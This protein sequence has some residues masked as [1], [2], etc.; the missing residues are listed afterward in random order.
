MDTNPGPLNIVAPTGEENQKPP[1]QQ[2]N[3]PSQPQKQT[4]RPYLDFLLVAISIYGFAVSLVVFKTLGILVYVGLLLVLVRL[5][6]KNNRSEL[7]I[8]I[9]VGS[10]L[11]FLLY[12]IQDALHLSTNSSMWLVKFFVT[13]SQWQ[14]VGFAPAVFSLISLGLYSLTHVLH[15][16]FGRLVSDSL[17][18]GI[19]IFVLIFSPFINSNLLDF[20]SAQKQQEAN[21]ETTQA[22]PKDGLQLYVPVDASPYKLEGILAEHGAESSPN[23]VFSAYS[24][25]YSN[26]QTKD[27]ISVYEGIKDSLFNPPQNCG[28]PSSRLLN[29]NSLVPC[30]LLTTTPKG[31]TVY[32]GTSEKSTSRSTN[33]I[34]PAPPYFTMVNNSL[35]TVTYRNAIN[36]E[37]A[38]TT[39]F[40]T[41]L[42]DSFEPA[43]TKTTEQYLDSYVR[44]TKETQL[45]SSLIQQAEPNWNFL[46]YAVPA[47]LYLGALLLGLE[48]IFRKSGKPTW[49]VYI[50]YY[51]AWQ[52]A[53]ISGH[54]G[55]W[56]LIVCIPLTT[57]AGFLTSIVSVFGFVLGSVMAWLIL[58]LNIISVPLFIYMSYGLGKKFGKSGLFT[59]LS[60][61]PPWVGVIIIGT[62]TS[63]YDNSFQLEMIDEPPV[64]KALA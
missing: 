12:I 53:K 57:A 43:S 45:S 37:S 11:Y 20:M 41:N 54:P 23:P 34:F 3:S 61:I 42:I 60:I 58:G 52:L 7:L 31:R 48:G 26:P 8:P 32:V 50:P 5:L 13:V 22:K 21:S 59:L 24:L 10:S 46:V 15:S 9:V 33:T 62:D 18:R 64:G 27:T 6:R 39:T 63:A 51:N 2:T 30:T 16:R 44:N 14:I 1:T 38:P 4:F 29:N 25:S 55:Y 17:L 36:I 28:D 47:S 56:A 19:F 40:I 35:I 49:K